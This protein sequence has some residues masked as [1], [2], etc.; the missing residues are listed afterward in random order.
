[1]SAAVFYLRAAAEELDLLWDLQASLGNR[2]SRESREYERDSRAVQLR[3]IAD[4][5]EAEG[6]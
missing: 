6:K 2:D 4:Q 3:S 1:M 5:L